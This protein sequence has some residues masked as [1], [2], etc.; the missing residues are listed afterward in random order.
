[1]NIKTKSIIKQGL[2]G[3]IV[4]ALGM[5]GFDLADGESFQGWKFIFNTTTFAISTGFLTHYTLKK[6]AEKNK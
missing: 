5:A 6:Q 3:G 1:M 4:F 2:L